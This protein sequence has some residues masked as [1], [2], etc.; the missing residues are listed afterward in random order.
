MRWK[1]GSNVRLNP[2]GISSTQGLISHSSAG[3]A[4]LSF[5]YHPRQL[6]APSSSIIRQIG[7]TMHLVRWKQHRTKIGENPRVKLTFVQHSN[8]FQEGWR[9]RH[10]SHSDRRRSCRRIKT[11][12]WMNLSVS[13][14]NLVFYNNHFYLGNNESICG[15][16]SKFDGDKTR[17]CKPNRTF[18]LWAQS[19]SISWSLGGL[20][21]C[22][23]VRP[24]DQANMIKENDVFPALIFTPLNCFFPLNC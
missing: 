22:V 19:D 18:N 14:L 12:W 24:C 3:K 1:Q 8:Y 5:S 7:P 4:S 20:A 10:L 13:A 11:L 6:M 9:G 23:W 16:R 17:E 15:Q 21:G 2:T